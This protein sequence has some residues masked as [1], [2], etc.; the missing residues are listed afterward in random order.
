MCV[1]QHGTSFL[2]LKRSKEPN[3]NAYTPVG[4]K[5]KPFESPRRA[6]IREVHEEAGVT[7][8][9]LKYCGT[10]TENSPTHYNWTGYVYLAHID[11]IPPPKCAEGILEWISIARLPEIFTPRT[12]VFMYRYILENR[13]F[14]FNADYDSKL[15]LIALHEEVEDRMLYTLDR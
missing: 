13:P 7:L 4:G 3:R 14:A 6:A 2:L 10:L 15:N 8:Q 11:L 1:L 9:A 12:D 5:L